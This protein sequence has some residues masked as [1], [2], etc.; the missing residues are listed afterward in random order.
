M[1]NYSCEHGRVICKTVLALSAQLGIEAD[2]VA[3]YL[4][5]KMSDFKRV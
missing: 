2:H 3:F 5:H 1:A 4:Q